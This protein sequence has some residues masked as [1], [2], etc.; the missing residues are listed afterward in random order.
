MSWQDGGQSSSSGHAI[1]PYPGLLQHPPH[2]SSMQIWYVFLHVCQG[3]AVRSLLNAW[4]F[5]TS[6][7]LLFWWKNLCI[8]VPSIGPKFIWVIF[9]RCEGIISLTWTSW[10]MKTCLL[11]SALMDNLDRLQ[12][13]YDYLCGG[14]ALR[15]VC[16]HCIWTWVNVVIFSCAELHL[17][18]P[19]YVC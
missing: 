16:R 17:Y 4:V 1:E 19:E 2:D 11:I 9:F 7:L 13:G 15:P 18:L 8:I 3:Y 5:R 10:T 12:A 6:V 14:M